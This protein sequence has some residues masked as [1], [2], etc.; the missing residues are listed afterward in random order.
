VLSTLKLYGRLAGKAL[1]HA[2]RAWP[3]ALILL[4]YTVLMLMASAQLSRLGMVGGF[5]AGFVIAAF[6]SSYLHL[7][8]QAVAGR[9]I[10]A[11][12]LRQS[13]GA[14]FWDVV[15]VLF[16]LWIIQLGVGMLTAN[17]GPR[18]SIVAALVGLTMAVFF[19]PVPELIYQGSSRSFALL[20]EAARFVSARWPEWLAPNLL[21][22][23]AVLAPLGLWERQSAGAT[24]LHLQALFSV[25]GLAQVI[26]SIP[27]ALAPLMLLFLHWAMVLRGLLFAELNA[28]SGLSARQRAIRDAWRR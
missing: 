11:L 24:L 18:G 20:G 8:A 25:S 7:L 15:S 27:L 12:D 9:P 4:V 21:F 16:A 26:A 6:I 19:N 17:M 22:A 28:T 10:T 14:R 1:R 3:L 2:L 23:A 5:I 13:F